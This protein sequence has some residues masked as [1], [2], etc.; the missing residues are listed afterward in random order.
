MKF[1]FAVDHKQNYR[2]F[3]SEPVSP[4]QLKFSKP[5]QVWEEAKKKLTFLSKKTLSQEQAFERAPKEEGR[6]LEIFYSELHE[7]KKIRLRFFFFLQRQR[8]RHMAVLI[9]ESLLLPFTALT[10]PLPGP[11]VLFYALALLMII[12][13]RAFRGINRTLHRDHR[14]VADPLLAEWERAVE[15]RRE[16]EYPALLARL[17][18]THGLKDLHKILWS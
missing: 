16:D 18:E 2:Y 11:N 4:V 15:D 10:M 6:P 9:G 5:R 12:Q 13:W 7:E 8:T 3:S 1:F 14:F 17:E